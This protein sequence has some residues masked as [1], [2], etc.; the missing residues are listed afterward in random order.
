MIEIIDILLSRVVVTDRPVF[1]R[2]RIDGGSLQTVNH[3]KR[4]GQVFLFVGRLKVR[5]CI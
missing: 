3:Y 4:G 1:F 2:S 5:E